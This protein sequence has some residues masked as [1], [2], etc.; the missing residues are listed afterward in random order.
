MIRQFQVRNW[1]YGPLAL[2]HLS[3]HQIILFLSRNNQQRHIIDILLASFARSVR[4]VM[5]P[6]FLP[7]FHGLR[8]LR[9]GHKRKGKKSFHKLPYGPRTR[10][11]RGIYELTALQQ[12]YKNSGCLDKNFLRTNLLFLRHVWKSIL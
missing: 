12:I 9:L 4:Q 11:I 5:D 2:G 7:C 1:P 8:A 3:K 6:F 10:L